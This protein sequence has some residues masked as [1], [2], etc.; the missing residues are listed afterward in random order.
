[1]RAF[2]WVQSASNREPLNVRTIYPPCDT[3]KVWVELSCSPAEAEMLLAHLQTSPLPIEFADLM[4]TLQ[5]RV[6]S[7]NL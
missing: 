2:S 3:P 1:M 7:E 5:G 4:R 6:W